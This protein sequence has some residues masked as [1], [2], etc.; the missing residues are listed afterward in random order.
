MLTPI[1]RWARSAG[2]ACL[3]TVEVLVLLAWLGPLAPLALAGDGL[4]ISF[5]DIALD[6]GFQ[7]RLTHGRALVAA[8]FDNDGLTDFYLGNPGDLLVSDDDSFVLW[9]EGPDEKGNYHF[10]KGEVLIKGDIAYTASAADYDNDGDQD[11]FVG[12]GGQEGIGLDH[13]FQNSGGVFT[14]VSEIAG[15]RGPKGPRGG[16]IPTATSAGTWADY[17]NDGDLDL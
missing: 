16:W 5:S 9:N 6:I 12:I 2:D 7:D 14:D 10:R 1:S 4:S 15:I 13:L 17:D 11:L 8:D 3:T